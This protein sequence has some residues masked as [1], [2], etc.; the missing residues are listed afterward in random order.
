[1]HP[2]PM[3]GLTFVEETRRSLAEAA[4]LSDNVA[5]WAKETLCDLLAQRQR[6]RDRSREMATDADLVADEPGCRMLQQLGLLERAIQQMAAI[7]AGCELSP[8]AGGVSHPGVG[9]CH[10]EGPD[11]EEEA[12]C[13]QEGSDSEEEAPCHQEGSGSEEEA[14]CPQERS[15]S[16]GEPTCLHVGGFT[17]TLAFERLGRQASVSISDG[18]VSDCFQTAVRPSRPAQ[19]QLAPAA[20]APAEED[21]EIFLRDGASAHYIVR[22]WEGGISDL[23]ALQ[24]ALHA[25]TMALEGLKKAL[26]AESIAHDVCMLQAWPPSPRVRPGS[27][28][29]GKIYKFRTPAPRV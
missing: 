29:P 2:L 21:W 16:E 10:Q 4:T 5:A 12:P 24:K 7:I 19:L 27:C 22:D 17:A 26:H 1:M 13:H 8:Q 18:K 20:W 3:S 23:E 28:D 9:P 11:S 14:S 15:D 6:L 25:E